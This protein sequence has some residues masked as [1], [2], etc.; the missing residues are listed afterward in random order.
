MRLFLFV[1]FFTTCATFNELIFF[2][3]KE[4]VSLNK[5]ESFIWMISVCKLLYVCLNNFVR[6]RNGCVWLRM[7][8]CVIVAVQV[9]VKEFAYPLGHV[10]VRS[11]ASVFDRIM[12]LFARLCVVLF[13]WMYV[14]GV[15]YV[16]YRNSLCVDVLILLHFNFFS[17][18]ENRQRISVWLSFA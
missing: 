14:Y 15:G 16:F 7:R 9:E 10:C 2:L 8:I 12:H 5:K 4:A 11:C 3:F 18:F 17:V 13:V 1:V 6:F